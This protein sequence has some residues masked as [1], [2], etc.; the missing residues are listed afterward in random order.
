MAPEQVRGMRDQIGARSDV[1]ALGALLY[2]LLTGRPPF[3]A[4]TKALLCEQVCGQEPVSPARLAPVAPDLA[5]VCLKCLHK[6]PARRFASAELLADDLRSVLRGEPPA[7]A[8]RVRA[9][10]RFWRWCRR[11]RALA[12]A[13]GL[14]ALLLAV[15]SVVSAGWAYHS[16]HQAEAV[17]SA[18]AKSQAAQLRQQ[19]QLAERHFDYAL[20]QCDRGEVGLGLLW[21]ARGL[22]TAPPGSAGLREALRAGM[23]AWHC[24]QFPLTGCHV[25]DGDVLAFGPDGRT[26]WVARADGS[27]YRRVL[28]TGKPDG[29]PLHHDVRVTSMATSADGKVVLTVTGQVAHLWHVGE[30]IPGPSF[31]APL[32]LLA[33]ALSADGRT[34]LTADHR[35]AGDDTGTVIRRWDAHTGQPLAPGCHHQGGLAAL[36]LSPDGRTILA[37]QASYGAILSWDAATGKPLGALP[38]P[39]G[40]YTVLAYAPDGRA[41]LT[42]SQIQTA[43]L[44]DVASGRPLGPTLI[45]G[46]PIRAVAFGKDGGRLR[47]LTAD[48][49][50]TVR[51]WAV[52][53]G[54]SP[55][56][57][58]PHKNPVR[59]VA[60]SPDGLL[61]AT[62]GFDGKACLWTTQGGVKLKELPHGVAITGLGYSPDGR[63]LLTASWPR[64]ARLWDVA[65]GKPRGE[66]L[67]HGKRVAA[68]AFSADGKRAATGTFGGTV[69]V[70][71]AATGA[72]LT[73]LR[74]GAQ[75]LA[76]AF[77]RQ[78]GRVLT[79]GSAG[80]AQFWDLTTG[81]PVGGA[82]R[83]GGTVWAVALA[84]D[85]RRL[86]TA[87][88][89]GTARLWDVATGQPHGQPMQHGSVVWVAAF[90][91]DGRRILTGSWDGT[92]RLWD[93]AT[94]RPRGQPLRHNDQVRAA[95]FSPDGRRVVTGSW[96]GTARLWDA[97]TGRPLGPRL[98]HQGRVCAVAAAAKNR[99][100]LTGSEDNR[101]RLWHVPPPVAGPVERLRLWAEVVTGLE[102]DAEGGVHPLDAPG[103]HQRRRRLRAL[104]GPPV[105]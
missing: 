23:A 58:L 25:A 71:D 31:T 50:R 36:A 13:S 72:P 99:M 37:A 89:D 90:S 102:L 41:V 9:R 1:Y 18:L 16:A 87:G 76:V 4:K 67:R 84:P 83:H 101:G 28:A 5:L 34:V 51:T 35:K 61:A 105:S 19:E 22:E 56:A 96:D 24:R 3:P 39:R 88:A 33:V 94:G 40:A 91:P 75:V 97:A 54:P 57:F 42:G 63:T 103:W 62:G 26:A 52:A 15:A 48:A 59:S 10:E 79:A 68:L 66:P 93:G 11:N 43:R 21:L 2:E 38:L 86:L 27:V 55:V 14:A 80:T 44:W 82:F 98:P 32:H 92:A 70:W 77:D 64:D 49:R 81:L 53:P 7:N 100:I 104:G 46:A 12:L 20:A 45:H 95:A 8:R 47:L 85:G 17:R 30:G 29:P 74:P 65:S 69:G 78:G 73:L 60:F 6:E